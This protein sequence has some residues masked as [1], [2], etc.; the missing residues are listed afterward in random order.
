[1]R[2]PG[3]AI[4]LAAML[5]QTIDGQAGAEGWAKLK[6]MAAHDAK[7][8]KVQKLHKAKRSLEGDLENY[9]KRAD[10][11]V[12]AQANRARALS[13]AVARGQ[14][15][16][17]IVDT[18]GAGK[19][20][21]LRMP[22]LADGNVIMSLARLV[23]QPES[24]GRVTARS[25]RRALALGGFMMGTLTDWERQGASRALQLVNAISEGTD[26]LLSTSTLM[27]LLIEYSGRDLLILQE[28][29]S[30]DQASAK[31]LLAKYVTAVAEFD[32]HNDIPVNI[33]QMFSDVALPELMLDALVAAAPDSVPADTRE[34]ALML[35]N[36]SQ[37]R[38]IAE[39]VHL[40]YECPQLQ[41]HIDQRHKMIQDGILRAYSEEMNR[42]TLK[43]HSMAHPVPARNIVAYGSTAV[44]LATGLNMGSKVEQGL[45]IAL[46]GPRSLQVKD[47]ISYFGESEQASAAASRSSGPWWRFG[48]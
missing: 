34:D 16:P 23:Q 19:L 7:F 13:A 44:W 1:M 14:K 29:I 33:E 25:I 47:V 27:Q 22:T 46:D 18:H 21:D 48:V 31:T 10:T 5:A 45:P 12:G 20:Q 37:R 3:Q 35:R 15:L 36:K 40:T 2:D 28:P 11:A 43:Q 9:T 26:Q 32:D 41:E 6:Q 4:R 38:S 42:S 30:S 24:E 8:R 39:A 17:E